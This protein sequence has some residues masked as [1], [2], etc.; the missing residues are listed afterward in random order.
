[1]NGLRMFTISVEFH[2]GREHVID[3]VREHLLAEREIKGCR[4]EILRLVRKAAHQN[5]CFFTYAHSS[6]EDAGPEKEDFDAT[7]VKAA[8]IVDKVFPDL[9]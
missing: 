4:L 3:V 9:T 7:T 2:V 5:G 6:E 8:A 1:M